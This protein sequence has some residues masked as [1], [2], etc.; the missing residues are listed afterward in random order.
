MAF[1]HAYGMCDDIPYAHLD[2]MHVASAHHNMPVATAADISCGVQV[3][4][5]P[6]VQ[7]SLLCSAVGTFS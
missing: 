4:G 1:H 5:L 3:N 7:R 2:C 6:A